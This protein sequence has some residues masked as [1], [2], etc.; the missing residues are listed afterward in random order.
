[1][2]INLKNEVSI[3]PSDFDFD[4]SEQLN[5]RLIWEDEYINDSFSGKTFFDYDEYNISLTD[6]IYKISSNQK[7]V[8]DLIG[9]FSPQILDEFEE[10]FL[11]FSYLWIGITDLQGGI[12]LPPYSPN[13][14]ESMILC[15]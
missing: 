4:K 7:K 11:Q 12:N 14:V 5:F 6:D 3:V 1:M 13:P 10:I 15:A 9:T 2:Y 8:F